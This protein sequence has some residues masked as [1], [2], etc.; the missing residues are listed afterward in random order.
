[1]H[2]KRLFF[3]LIG[4]LI[5]AVL[6]IFHHPAHFPPFEE[7]QALDSYS[8]QEL[9][10]LRQQFHKKKWKKVRS[11]YNQTLTGKLKK[12]K[13]N[14]IPK[15]IHQIFLG[16]EIPPSLVSAMATWRSKHPDWDYHLWTPTELS[17]L[18]LQNEGEL[19][20]YEILLQFGGVFI[21]NDLICE[22]SLDLLCESLDFFAELSNAIKSPHLSEAILGSTPGHPILRHVIERGRKHPASL[23][24]AYFRV[25]KK[26]PSLVNVALPT[27][28]LSKKQTP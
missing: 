12:K 3:L 15:V 27:E 26:S 25:T 6:Y 23:T 13:R 22:R 16:E 19:L 24:K 28:F 21:E 4:L 11:T 5:P 1:M 2:N 8:T 20:R 7:A 18:Y 17:C 14:R 10:T 9:L